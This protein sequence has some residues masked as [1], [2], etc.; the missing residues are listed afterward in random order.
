ML[1]KAKKYQSTFFVTE[2]ENIFFD[3]IDSQSDIKINFRYYLCFI[4]LT[5]ISNPKHS[6]FECIL[7]LK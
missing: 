6:L 1:D 3:V 4:E 2:E 7:I 5:E